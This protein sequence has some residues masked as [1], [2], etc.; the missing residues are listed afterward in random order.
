MTNQKHRQITFIT[1]RGRIQGD[2]VG[3][4]NRVSA[5]VVRLNSFI[6]QS[7]DNWRLNSVVWNDKQ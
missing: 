5:D 2:S 7:S 6:K 3:L 1:I 4:R